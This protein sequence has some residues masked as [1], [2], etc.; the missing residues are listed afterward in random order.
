MVRT[1]GTPRGASMSWKRTGTPAHNNSTPRSEEDIPTYQA[2]P[3]CQACGGSGEVWYE[4]SVYNSDGTAEPDWTNEPCECVFYKWV[5]KPDP[6][7]V[8]CCGVGAVQ[9]RLMMDG[10]ET[11][12]FHDCVCLRYVKESDDDERSN[13]HKR[14]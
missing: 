8:E 13:T 12:M 7:C 14:N 11:I 3:A 4:H 10:E 1:T 9:E 5:V 2:N 6:N